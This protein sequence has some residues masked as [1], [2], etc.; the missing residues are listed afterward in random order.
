MKSEGRGEIEPYYCSICDGWHNGHKK[1]E[2]VKIV[3]I[4]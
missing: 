1:K 2:K 4:K 3:K